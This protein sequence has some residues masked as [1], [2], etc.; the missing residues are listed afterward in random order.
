MSQLSTNYLEE[1]CSFLAGGCRQTTPMPA[2][3]HDG[4]RV[5]NWAFIAPTGPGHLAVT[6]LTGWTPLYTK[7]LLS[8]M[9]G[10]LSHSLSL[11]EIGS[12]NKTMIPN[13]AANQ[14]Q[15]GWKRKESVCCNGSVKVQTSTLF[16]CLRDLCLNNCR[17]TLVNWSYK[18]EWTK[19]PPLQCERLISSYCKQWLQVIAAKDGSTSR[20][21]LD[22]PSHNKWHT[23]IYEKKKAEQNIKFEPTRFTRSIKIT[24]SAI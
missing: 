7:A 2:V 4:G 21:I 9:W 10:H 20:W 18:E 13:T 14:Q 6:E 15:N 3:K 1:Y 23:V 12:C 16:K 24:V 8:Q 5:T 22:W 19:F 11:A 17:E